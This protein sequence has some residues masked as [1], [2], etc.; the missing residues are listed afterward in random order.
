MSRLRGRPLPIPTWVRGI[1]QDVD[2]GQT[3]LGALVDGENLVHLRAPRLATRGGSRVLLTLKD[4]Q[5][6]PAEVSHVPL[7]APLSPPGAVVVSFA[8]ATDK[9][10]VTALT[11]D[12][13]FSSGSEATSR[14]A[15]PV[16]W[17]NTEAAANYGT[18][19]V[20]ALLFEKL[21]LADARTDYANRKTFISVSGALPPAVAEPTFAFG[22]GAAQVIRPY[23]IEE[24]NGVLFLAGYGSEDAGDADRPELLRHSFLGRAPDAVD[25]FDPAAWE[26]VGAK[27]DRITAARKGRGLLLVAKAN[28]F[29][30][31]SGFPRALP[32]W[33]FALDPVH[34]TQGLGIVNPH[35]LVYVE[36]YWYGLG[37]SGALRSDG[38]NLE[39]LMGPRQRAWR[40]MNQIGNGW[41]AYHPERHVILFGLH[42]AEAV[43]GRSATYPWTVW[44]WDI[45]RSVWAPDW[46]PGIDLFMSAAVVTET[47]Q[48]PGAPPT[49]ASTT[50]IT[51]GS[52]RANWTNGD[53]TASTEYW[54]QDVTAGGT[55]I[56][57]A[58]LDPGVTFYDVT[59]R[60]DHTHYAW[61][62]RH[63][64][65]GVHS[66]FT[67]NQ[68]AQTLILPPTLSF[69]S[70]TGFAGT[71]NMR[72]Q[73]LAR[74]TTT[75]TVQKSPAGM[76]SWTTIHTYLGDSQGAT[77]DTVETTTPGGADFRVKSSDAGWPT[78]DST[79]N[80]I[81]GI[82]C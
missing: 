72:W 46:K 3:P 24:Y 60:N 6:V 47:A 21:Y 49:G 10:Y 32:G 52:W 68:T 62:V 5:G 58:V 45:E 11:A 61:R 14:T 69:L 39:T 59:P 67:T 79:W 26:I 8:D 36:P 75:L 76:G 81:N 18:R 63:V 1:M 54:E 77:H 82:S 42:P 2:P 48:G 12:L 73:T 50:N 30:R 9:H 27:G 4:D 13:A 57:K 20:G 53:A 23:A 40:S 71:A 55:W 43:A 66:S 80:Q 74:G 16:N 41:V 33:Q 44:V 35:C 65:A 56:L 22:A 64:K 19:P 7:L 38:F 34:N 17:N 25:G 70:C 28:E 15:L 78:Q 51:T 37:R 29:Y 31:V